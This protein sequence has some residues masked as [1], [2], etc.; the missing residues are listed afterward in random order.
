MGA[1]RG[2]PGRP[3]G[4]AAALLFSAALAS[5]CDAPPVD[6]APPVPL[7]EFSEE[8]ARAH[9]EWAARCRHAPSEESCERLADPTFYD[10]RRAAD[11]QAAGRLTYDAVE[12]GRCVRAM[13]E[14]SCAARAFSD[15]AC[16]RMLV[17]ELSRGEACTAHGEC[18]GG[19]ECE[20]RE[21]GAQCCL[22]VC[23]APEPRGAPQP[24]EPA[25]IGESCDT[26]FDCVDEAYCERD[27]RCEPLPER[28][29]E[30]CLFGC[31][32]GDLYCDLDVLECREYADFG[33][34]CDPEGEGAPPCNSAWAVCRGGECA[35]RPGEGESCAR[36]P[37]SCIAT[38]HC[39]TGV[40]RSLGEPGDPCEDDGECAWACD[41]DAGVCV[42]YET[43]RTPD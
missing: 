19:A 38:T 7:A 40:C 35:P 21:C 18:E 39:D 1:S 29:G 9:C 10:A 8:A 28:A 42:A 27:G 17:P 43:C 41:E 15:P 6:A 13:A 12:A 37:A 24:P 36:D 5:A 16:D 32:T 20:D 14:A 30:R 25:E 26:H 3:L 31:L 2:A 22:G 11:S 4:A 33:E 23:G 34:A